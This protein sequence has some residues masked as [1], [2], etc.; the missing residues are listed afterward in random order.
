[1]TTVN[2]LLVSFIVQDLQPLSVVENRGFCAL[3]RCLDQRVILP[4]RS[5]ITNRLLPKI[6]EE[7]K[8]G[9]LKQLALVKNVCLTTYLWSSKSKSSF[10][11]FTVHFM[12]EKFEIMS[13]ALLTVN[14]PENHTSVNLKIRIGNVIEEWS[15]TGKVSYIITDNAVNIVKAVNDSS[16]GNIPCFAHTLSLVVKSAMEKLD[17]I[18]DLVKKCRECV[19][20]FRQSSLATSKLSEQ[21]AGVESHRKTVLQQDVPTRWNSTVIMIITLLQLKDQVLAVLG[22]MQQSKLAPNESEW[23]ALHSLILLLNLFLIS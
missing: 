17:S 5:T 3:V 10:M 20:Y 8:A 23:D 21:C 18:N 1:M 14:V 12:N 13:K 11:T 4:C 2:N 7:V 6:Y 19:T 9:L 15:L 22:V 16:I